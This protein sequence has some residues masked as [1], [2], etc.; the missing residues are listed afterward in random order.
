MRRL[1]V[2]ALDTPGPIVFLTGVGLSIESNLPN[3]LA[4]GQSWHSKGRLYPARELARHAAFVEDADVVWSWY[5]WRWGVCQSGEPNPAHDAISLASRLF[6]GRIRI[7]C[8]SVDGLHRAAG[9]PVR[10][11]C[12]VHGYVGAMRCAEGCVGLSRLPRLPQHPHG[13]GQ[14]SEEERA[15]L[16]CVR[17][18]GPARP[19][20]LWLDETYDELNYRADTALGTAG[21]ASALIVAG[22][23]GVSAIGRQ[24]VERCVERRVPIIV[25]TPELSEIAELATR[26]SQGVHLTGTAAQVVPTLVTELAEAAGV[27][28][29][30]DAEP[31][32]VRDVVAPETILAVGAEGGCTTLQGWQGPDGHWRF[33]VNAD[34]STFAEFMPDEFTP[35]QLRRDGEWVVGFERALQALDR[36]VPWAQ[37]SPVRVHPEFTERILR[38]VRIRVE[39]GSRARARRAILERWQ[40]ACSGRPR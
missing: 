13:V 7:V 18:G 21:K 26:Q 24:V 23:A 35:G 37:L 11:T 20:V 39:A 31:D 6:D 15:M 14:L 40:L 28:E 2:R 19:H 9:G 5:L 1:L 22:A 29:R 38:A 27:S 32:S 8:E 3:F 36:D 33:R 4:E 34:A 25:I 30:L 12:E 10:Y 17:C 16:T